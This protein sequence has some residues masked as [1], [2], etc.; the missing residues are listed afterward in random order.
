MC[1]F[2]GF[3]EVWV[4]TPDIPSKSRPKDVHRGLTIYLL[5]QDWYEVAT[6][7]RTFPRWKASSITEPSCYRGCRFFVT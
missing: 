1:E 5:N 2:W 6:T 7:S 3:P 4:E